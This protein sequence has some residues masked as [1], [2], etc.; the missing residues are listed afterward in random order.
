M[1][2][3]VLE[4]K[5]KAFNKKYDEIDLKF[6]TTFP[7]T[8]EFKFVRI[9]QDTIYSI[10]IKLFFNIFSLIIGTVLSLV[11]GIFNAFMQFVFVWFIIPFAVCYIIEINYAL[12]SLFLYFYMNQYDSMC[13]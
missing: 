2:E 11:W 1:T 5:S 9:I 3:K 12:F 6:D 8:D 4:N 7:K 10:T 13:I